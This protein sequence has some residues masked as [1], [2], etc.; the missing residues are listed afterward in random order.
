MQ[1][2]DMARELGKTIQEDEQF[3]RFQAAK[4]EPEKDE[5]LQSVNSI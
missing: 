2:L 1:I 4:A 3:K 5:A